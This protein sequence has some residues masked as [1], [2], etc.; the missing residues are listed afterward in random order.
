MAGCKQVCRETG[1]ILKNSPA[2]KAAGRIG[3][4]ID[5]KNLLS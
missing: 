4:F 1:T 2:G 3:R 5:V